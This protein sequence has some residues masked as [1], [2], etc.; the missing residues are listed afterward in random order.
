MK[1]QGTLRKGTSVQ[2]SL[3]CV[4]LGSHHRASTPVSVTDRLQLAQVGAPPETMPT[5]VS[6]EV[7]SSELRGASRE[8]AS[9]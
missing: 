5:E 3:P 9:L 1:E 7:P 8:E 4:A 2:A 6:R